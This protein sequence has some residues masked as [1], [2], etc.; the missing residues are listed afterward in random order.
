MCNQAS[1][2]RPALLQSC[3]ISD[4]K[5]VLALA[6]EQSSSISMGLLVGEAC[7]CENDVCGI[8]C[9]RQT[10]ELVCGA[11]EDLVWATG[12]LSEAPIWGQALHNISQCVCACGTRTRSLS[13]I[14]SLPCCRRL[15][16]EHNPVLISQAGWMHVVSLSTYQVIEHGHLWINFSHRA[17]NFSICGTSSD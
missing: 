2:L 14:V 11:A 3:S 15:R 10:R 6:G 13:A 7:L 5:R 16:H 4:P 17:W 1:S 12:L 9:K 8:S